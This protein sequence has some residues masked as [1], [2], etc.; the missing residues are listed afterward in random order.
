MTGPPL[1]VW[2][3]TTAEAA[4]WDDAWFDRDDEDPD[5]DD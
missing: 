1:P 5:P 2:E 4:A 3:E